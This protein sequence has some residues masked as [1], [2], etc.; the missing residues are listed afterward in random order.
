[1]VM[2]TTYDNPTYIARAVA[3]GAAAYL[4]KGVDRDEMLQVLRALENG[5]ALISR[6][7]LVRL[8]RNVARVSAPSEDPAEP[9][10]VS[11]Q[12]VLRLLAAGLTNQ[13]IGA[14][15]SIPETAVK[16]HIGHII[17]KLGVSDR[18]Q[19]AVWAVRNGFIHSQG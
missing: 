19:A 3:G 1:V 13:E 16:T 10:T 5:D 7:D 8:L 17:D 12:A 18:T 14:L 11:E 2:L 9:L 4:L 6:E 15:Q